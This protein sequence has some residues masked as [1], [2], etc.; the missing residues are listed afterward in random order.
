LGPWLA[1]THTHR[2]IWKT[3]QKSA[4][5]SD[6]TVLDSHFGA[7]MA[8]P[9][10]RRSPWQYSIP[11]FWG[12]GG[13]GTTHHCSPTSNRLRMVWSSPHL[14]HT[15]TPNALTHGAHRPANGV[16][17]VR[18]IDGVGKRSIDGVPITDE[19]CRPVRGSTRQNAAHET[20]VGTDTRCTRAR[21]FAQLFAIRCEME[22]PTSLISRLAT[23]FW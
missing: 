23:G 21:D 11:H 15:L 18:S 20:V 10:N 14:S 12:I 19:R 8:G 1:L 6:V 7:S 13:P 4:V 2:E 3:N 16:P 9:K 22:F 5:T 17:S